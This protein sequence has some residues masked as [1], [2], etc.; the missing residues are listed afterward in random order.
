MSSD[1]P[2]CLTPFHPRPQ[3]EM[4]NTATLFPSK[5]L[6]KLFL[7]TSSDVKSSFP[8]T[9]FQFLIILNDKAFSP[10]QEFKFITSCPKRTWVTVCCLHFCCNLQQAGRPLSFL[11]P[12]FSMHNQPNPFRFPFLYLIYNTPFYTI[13]HFHNGLFAYMVTVGRQSQVHG[14]TRRNLAS[15]L[16]M[17]HSILKPIAKPNFFLYAFP[18]DCYWGFLSLGKGHEQYG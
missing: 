9:L 1:K 17:F 16:L 18:P 5:Y 3:A 13:W 7:R 8:G 15:C 14:I 6:S 2:A 11:T 4:K 12:A 10:L